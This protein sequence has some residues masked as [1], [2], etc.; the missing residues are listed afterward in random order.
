M[1]RRLV[2]AG[3]GLTLAASLALTGWA[4]YGI[5]QD[6]ALAAFTERGAD[7]IRAATD[8]LMAREATPER[9]A[10]LLAIRLEESPRNWVA[11]T[12]LEGVSADRALPLPAGLL[13]AR[14]A[15]WAADT[16]W[17]T[18]AADCAL[19][20]YDPGTCT[21]S[22]V[23]VCQVPIAL[24]PVGDIAGITRGAAAWAAGTDVDEID[25]GLSIVGLAATALVLA[26]G[27]SAALVKAGAGTARLARR[28]GLL[29]PR[30]TALGSDALRHG[31]DWAALPAARSADDLARTLRPAALAPVIAVTTDM[32]RLRTATGSTEALHLL[33]YIDDAPDARRLANAAE[34]LGPRTVGRI[35]VLGKARLMRATLRW[36]EATWALLAGIWGMFAG[37]AG[38]LGGAAQ[39]L[40]LRLSRR[41]A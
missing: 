19:C 11:I 17:A 33:R 22:N 15:A 2:R 39:S 30:L 34:A 1:L 26:S 3:L 9:I 10:A 41:L 21:L 29:S 32:G 28:M 4:G 40:A 13:A 35:E 23:L 6:P 20:A 5:A 27:G 24:T 25:V 37:L 31:I 16:G 12:S 38:L 8:R 14:E 36:S 7:E 18:L